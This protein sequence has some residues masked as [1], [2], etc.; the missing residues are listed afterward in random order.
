MNKW[1]WLV[2]YN[3]L[4][5]TLFDLAISN[6]IGNVIWPQVWQIGKCSI[7]KYSKIPSP[8]NRL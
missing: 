3:A 1:E 8:N 6:F 4:L 2:T 7:S 5:Y